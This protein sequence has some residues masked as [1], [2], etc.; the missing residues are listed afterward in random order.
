M[1]VFLLFF[2]FIFLE[3]IFSE[4][5]AS[6]PNS[7]KVPEE[8]EYEIPQRNFE[9]DIEELDLS[10]YE[11]DIENIEELAYEEDGTYVT[12]MYVYIRID[13]EYKDF[14]KHMDM[15]KLGEKY[16]TLLQ[17]A[18]IETQLKITGVGMFTCYYSKKS[19]TDDLIT[20]FL[21]QKEVDFLEVGFDQK[22]PEGRSSP[23]T[24]VQERK[25]LK[26]RT[27]NEEL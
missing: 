16:M 6:V 22:F 24:T 8:T 3:R 2:F 11:D 13:D 26:D 15:I 17:S 25:K 4:E 21:I 1:K 18:M 20:Y 5:T 27:K 23:I 12:Q 7:E 19:Q 14:M 10:G 9:K